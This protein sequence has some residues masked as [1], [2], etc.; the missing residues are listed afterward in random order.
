MVA[1]LLGLLLATAPAPFVPTLQIGDPAPETVLADQDGRPFSFRALRGETALVSFAYTRCPDADECPLVSGKFLWLQ[2]HSRGE[3]IALVEITLDP[4]HDR[5]A[6]MRAYGKLFEADPKR[7]KL[8]SGDPAAVR[9][10]TTRLGGVVLERRAGGGLV[11]G[12]AVVVVG[13]DG[14]IVDRIP[15]AGWAPDQVLA[16]ALQTARRP[17]DPWARLRLALTRGVAALCGG[18]GASG[19]AVWTALLIFSV[20][21]LGIGFIV[22]P[23]FRAPQRR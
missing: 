17:S 6:V 1:A 20:L 7:W 9:E 2:N 3:P 18:S 11:H 14:R 8:V 4:D 21:L 13:P 12:E 15:G 23:L 19:V 10:V 5:P 16:L 22:M